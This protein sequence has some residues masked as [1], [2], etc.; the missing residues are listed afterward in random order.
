M[1]N[2]IGIETTVK[3][4]IYS[5]TCSKVISEMQILTHSRLTSTKIYVRRYSKYSLANCSVGLSFMFFTTPLSS[6]KSIVSVA[7]QETKLVIIVR[8]V[9]ILIVVHDMIILLFSIFCLFQ[10]LPLWIVHVLVYWYKYHNF[11]C[12]KFN[13]ESYSGPF[14]LICAPPPPLIK[15]SGYPMGE[16]GSSS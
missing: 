16:R 2:G 12:Y 14:H 13:I 10:F 1:R 9:H 3:K 8:D 5:T 6:A 7:Y 11:I 15:G 4:Y